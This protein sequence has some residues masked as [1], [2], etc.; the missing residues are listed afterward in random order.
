ME[1]QGIPGNTIIHRVYQDIPKVY[2]G[3]YLGMTRYARRGRSPATAT[4]TWTRR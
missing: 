1:Y 2:N 3:L 4:V